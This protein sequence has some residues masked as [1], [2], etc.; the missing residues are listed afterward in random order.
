[1]S[2]Q[3]SCSSKTALSLDKP[4]TFYY[5]WKMRPPLCGHRTAI[6]RVKKRFS[7]LRCYKYEFRNPLVSFTVDLN[8]LHTSTKFL[9]QNIMGNHEL[10]PNTNSQLGLSNLH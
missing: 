9:L 2:F 3:A 10:K 4:K 1:M 7:W 6:Y 5:K 8:N